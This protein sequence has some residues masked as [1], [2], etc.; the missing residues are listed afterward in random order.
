MFD[1]LYQASG[2]DLASIP[3]HYLQNF[4][5]TYRDG[6]ISLIPASSKLEDFRELNPE[7]RE[8]VLE[9]LH[10]Q[11]PNHWPN[12]E[13]IT[14]IDPVA[15][16]KEVDSYDESLEFVEDNLGTAEKVEKV[17]KTVIE[18]VFGDKVHSIRD[19][20]GKYP[21]SGNN[22]LQEDDG[23]FAGLFNHEHFQFHFEI[24]PT[25]LGWICTYRLEEKTLDGIP[26]KVK[27]KK[28]DDKKFEEYKRVRTKGWR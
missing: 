13:K 3:S 9:V 6:D 11:N 27:D 20:R 7:E 2:G 8:E 14:R 18:S 28:R 5:H 26:E 24:A 21:S 22:F 19:R 16:L 23:T 4:T 1:L 17:L 10:K 12:P 15:L 25:E